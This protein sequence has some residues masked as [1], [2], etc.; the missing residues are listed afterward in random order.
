[1]HIRGDLHVK[2]YLESDLP[3][4]TDCKM[5]YELYIEIKGFEPRIWRKIQVDA[6]IKLDKLHHVIQVAMGWTNSHLYSFMIGNEEFSLK[7]YEVDIVYQDSKKIGLIEFKEDKFQYVYDFG[8]Y[9]EHQIEIVQKLRGKGP[10]TAIC[11]DGR[12]K[13]PPE[14]VGGIP[15]YME[16]LKTMKDD[17]HPERDSYIEWYGSV[18]DPRDLRIPRINYL[19][20]LI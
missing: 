14:D 13:C 3:T 18:F 1:M 10:A 12:G 5:I 19:L 9:W 7:E 17:N 16:F 15:G 6:N 8:D 2:C 11:V 4:N 20:S